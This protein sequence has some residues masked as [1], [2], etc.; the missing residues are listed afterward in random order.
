MNRGAASRRDCPPRKMVGTVVL[1]SVQD[2]W[3]H[4]A[5]KQKAQLLLNMSVVV[6]HINYTIFLQHTES[7]N[8][9]RAAVKGLY[10]L[11]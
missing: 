2:G 3:M 6:P 11:S 9:S 10:V 8:H 5:A 4:G 1:A 7:N